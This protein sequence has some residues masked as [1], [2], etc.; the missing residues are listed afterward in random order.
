MSDKYRG[1]ES[2]IL[3]T[4]ESPPIDFGFI[5]QHPN[6]QPLSEKE[7]VRFELELESKDQKLKP[8]EMQSSEISEDKHS[9]EYDRYAKHE[10]Y[11]GN[12]KLTEDLG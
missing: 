9:E 12:L 7:L 3:E 8:D 11:I 10:I 1:I 6:Y 2:L 5:K 4:K